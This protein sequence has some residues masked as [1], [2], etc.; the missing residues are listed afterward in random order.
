[1]STVVIV[2]ISILWLVCL[3]SLLFFKEL[4]LIFLTTL[5]FLRLLRGVFAPMIPSIITMIMF[6]YSLALVFQRAETLKTAFQSK[7]GSRAIWIL[8]FIY[9]LWFHP[10]N[11]YILIVIKLKDV[12]NH[13][14]YLSNYELTSINH[15]IIILLFQYLML[16]YIGAV[17]F[18][19]GTNE[20][21]NIEP[22]SNNE[23][24][25]WMTF[26]IFGP[27]S[28]P[29]SVFISSLFSRKRSKIRHMRTVT[30]D[31]RRM[32]SQ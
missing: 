1:M 15:V 23:V 17:V 4:R 6:L 14:K 8:S 26:C 24:E 16:L 27:F 25:I 2:F 30:F 18:I 28:Y 9:A 7:I 19:F 12:Y 22:D 21:R 31:A 13:P 20:T 10:W 3:G 5:F 11:S 32:R 29:Y